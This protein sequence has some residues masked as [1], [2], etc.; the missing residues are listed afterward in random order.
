MELTVENI[1]DKLRE[2][3]EK[4]LPKEVALV[5]Y[6]VV[7]KSQMDLYHGDTDHFFTE[8][9]VKTMNDIMREIPRLFQ[10]HSALGKKFWNTSS[11]YGSKHFLEHNTGTETK[12]GIY[13]YNGQFIF[14]MLLLGYEMKPIDLK[15]N[16]RMSF[17]NRLTKKKDML[18]IINPNTTFNC[19]YRDLSKVVCECGLQYTKS[20]WKQHERS[21]THQLIIAAKHAENDSD[22]EF[23]EY[24]NEAIERLT[25]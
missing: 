7:L 9:S 19:S 14:A 12:S 8:H 11:S 18:E 13:C 22:T 21:K 20:A 23:G 1:S 3:S 16:H 15:A 25:A 2:I 4:C 5:P 10:K 6:G 24:I 17:T